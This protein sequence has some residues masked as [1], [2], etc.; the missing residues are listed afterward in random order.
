MSK[1]LTVGLLLF[2]QPRHIRLTKVHEQYHR[3]IIDRYDTDVFAHAWSYSD[4]YDIP[5]WSAE[6]GTTHGMESLENPEDVILQKYPT[7]KEILVEPQKTFVFP[8]RMREF[9]RTKWDGNPFYSEQNLHNIASQLY[10]IS[11]VA[12]LAATYGDMQFGHKLYDYWILAR[13][14]TELVDFPKLEELPNQVD[15][16]MRGWDPSIYMPEGGHWNDLIQI[17]GMTDQYETVAP[18]PEKYL[19]NLYFDMMNPQVYENLILPIPEFFKMNAYGLYYN[20]PSDAATK[21]PM[22]VNVIRTI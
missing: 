16:F 18:R 20:D 21:L 6:K 2:G 15:E 4:N 10:S 13:Y 8:K 19:R 12:S 17:Y 3:E 5:S 11:A 9:M 1:D 14:D 22:Y 7:I